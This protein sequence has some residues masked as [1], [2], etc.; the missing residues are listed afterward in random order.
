MHAR[1]RSGDGRKAVVSRTA[2]ALRDGHC[3]AGGTL[4]Q[5]G[6]DRDGDGVLSKDEID[7][8]TF[9]CNR[10]GGPALVATVSVAAEPSGPRCAA[11]GQRIT[12]AHEDESGK[13]GK[14]A[15]VSYACDGS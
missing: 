2:L 5:S 13:S 15:R 10:F 8:A 12:V 14:S 4:V 6:I 7:R 9:A 1:G 11:G 3:P